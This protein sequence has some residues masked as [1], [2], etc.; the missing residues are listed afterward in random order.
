MIGRIMD[1]NQLKENLIRLA[2]A[3]PAEER[4]PYAFE[5]RVMARLR[6]RAEVDIWAYWSRALWSAAAPC[7]AVM[8]ITGAWATLDA[9]AE[10][11]LDN[12]IMAPTEAMGETW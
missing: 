2:R 9:E 6:S 8:L 5:K 10:L 3:L 7:V 4:A 11:D 1:P 12:A